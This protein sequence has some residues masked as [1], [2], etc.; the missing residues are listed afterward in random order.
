MSNEYHPQI[1]DH[2]IGG[3]S[4]IEILSIASQFITSISS[5]NIF[6]ALK[7][8]YGNLFRYLNDPMGLV[9]VLKCNQTSATFKANQKPL[10]LPAPTNPPALA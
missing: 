8:Y 4:V 6:N 3:V 9:P 7:M 5:F 10:V 2:I 1:T